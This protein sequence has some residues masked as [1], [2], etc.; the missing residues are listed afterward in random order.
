MLISALLATSI[1]AGSIEDY[2]P[3]QPGIKWTYEDS[4]G[5]Q[6]VQ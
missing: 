1:W 6:L 5:R 4:D 2:F 3:H